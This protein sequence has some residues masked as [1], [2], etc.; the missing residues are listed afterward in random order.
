MRHGAQD[1]CSSCVSKSECE[2]QAGVMCHQLALWGRGY[3]ADA[4]PAA[5]CGAAAD[6]KVVGA[7]RAA[8]TVIVSDQSRNAA[9]A[10]A[11]AVRC[12]LLHLR[13]LSS[14]VQLQAPP[15]L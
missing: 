8:S 2:Q 9:E 1:M 5:G 15:R 6:L 12:G 10:D 7:N 4:Y 14:G 11:Q 13:S 3:R